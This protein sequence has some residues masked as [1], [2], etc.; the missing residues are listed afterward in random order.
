MSP[1]SEES[2]FVSGEP[3]PRHSRVF[4]IELGSLHRLAARFWYISWC[5]EIDLKPSP[6]VLT[7]SPILVI[8]WTPPGFC[9][10]RPGGSPDNRGTSLCSD[11]HSEPIACLHCSWQAS[12]PQ[13]ISLES[14]FLSH[15]PL[16][17]FPA[18]YHQASRLDSAYRVWF[19]TSLSNL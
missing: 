9:G 16:R 10:K 4:P 11:L 3:F 17:F 19:F 2:L 8:Q 15:L 12:F 14:D 13:G 5:Q 7:S 6:P 18:G 1:N